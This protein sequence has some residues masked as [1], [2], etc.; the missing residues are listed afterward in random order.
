MFLIFSIGFFPTIACFALAALT[1]DMG[2]KCK[3]KDTGWDYWAEDK[4]HL[5]KN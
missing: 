3:E 5:F 2:C 4:E 1:M